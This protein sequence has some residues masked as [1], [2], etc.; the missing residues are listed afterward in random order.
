MNADE[1]RGYSKGY[2]AGRRRQHQE[3]LAET[4]RKEQQAFLDKVFIAC[5]AEA[6]SVQG[7]KIGDKPVSAIPDRITVAR[8]FALDALRRRPRV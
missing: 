6:M 1:S 2:A 3:H 8:D 4:L 5:V 7:W